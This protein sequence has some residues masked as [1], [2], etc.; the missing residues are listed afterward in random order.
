MDLA[1]LLVWAIEEEIGIGRR[2]REELLMM[3]VAEREIGFEGLV[4]EDKKM[5][6]EEWVYQLGY[7]LLGNAIRVVL[8]IGMLGVLGVVAVAVDLGRV[9]EV[10]LLVLVQVRELRVGREEGMG[11]GKNRLLLG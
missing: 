10:R 8:G 9:I 7:R 11:K 1:P 5:L 3:V 4:W 2:E 6:G